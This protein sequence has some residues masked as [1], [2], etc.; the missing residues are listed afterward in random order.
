MFLPNSPGP[1]FGLETE[2]GTLLWLVHSSWPMTWPVG[3]HTNRT[4]MHEASW[5]VE[6]ARYSVRDVFS[7]MKY[8]SVE[9]KQ[10]K[11]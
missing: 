8:P 4:F 1:T 5:N 7:T 11:G 3:K 10:N 2:D 6:Q 9:V